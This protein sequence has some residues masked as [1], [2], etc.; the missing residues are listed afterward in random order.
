M[1]PCKRARDGGG[2]NAERLVDT[3]ENM[4]ELP[5]K[6]TPFSTHERGE[7]KTV[8]EIQDQSKDKQGAGFVF[9]VAKH[10]DGGEEEGDDAHDRRTQ[11]DVQQMHDG[12]RARVLSGKFIP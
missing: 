6:D 10:P 7:K 11:E 3:E 1:K 2:L 5:G 12:L 8:E 9:G 4:V